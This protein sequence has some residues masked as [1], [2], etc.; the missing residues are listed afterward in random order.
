MNNNLAYYMLQNFLLQKTKKKEESHSD[1]TKKKEVEN[2][3]L[4][5]II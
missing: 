5:K 2:K 3:E 4:T 1:I